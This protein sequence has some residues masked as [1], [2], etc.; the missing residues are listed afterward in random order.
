MNKTTIVPI[1][2]SG[3]SGKRLWPLSRAGFPKQ[4]LALSSSYKTLFQ[5]AIV[6]LSVDFGERFKINP[7]IVVTNEA[8]RFLVTEQLKEINYGLAKLLLEPISRNTAAALT[9]AALE[10]N[11]NSENPILVVVSADQIIKDQHAF[12]D[13]IHKSIE[14]AEKKSIVILGVPPSKPETAYGYIHCSKEKGLLGEFQVNQFVEKPDQLTAQH[15]IKEGS[16]FWNAG[17]FIMQADVW[18]QAIQFFRKDIATTTRTAWLQKTIDPDLKFIRPHRESFELVP[19]D[20]IDYAVMEKCP[21]SLFDLKMIPLKAG[22]S[23]LGSWNALWEEG[24]RDENNNVTHGDV[25]LS[26]SD[27]CLIHASSRLVAAVGTKNL[28]IVETPDAVLIADRNQD[29]HIKFLVESL[30][31]DK[32]EEQLFHRKVNRPWGWYD[33]IDAGENFKV[34]RI[35]VKPGASLSLQKHQSRAEHW[36]VVKGIAEIT[37]GEK[38][39]TL[40]ENESTFIPQGQLHRLRNSTNL[41][42]EIIEVQSGEYLG[43][44]D[45]IRYDDTYGRGKEY[46]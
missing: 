39:I 26:Q 4:F 14:L 7:A 27:Q 31:E 18:L 12:T 21:G 16:Y 1:I 15:Y 5:E 25:L 11:Q 23:D 46:E 20:S 19:S 13:A 17:I 24:Q 37:N 3:G 34:K 38:T 42:L 43:E 36:V 28:I 44:D 35:Y 45:I 9:L 8:H 32:R 41:P 10:A 2:L 40:K 33:S 30:V 22:W 6:R 29:Q